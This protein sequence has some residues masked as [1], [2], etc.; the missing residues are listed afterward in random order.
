MSP[1]FKPTHKHRLARAPR[2]GPWCERV[3]LPDQREL[4][5][6]PITAA[7]AEPIQAGFALLHPDEIRKRYGYAMKEI[8]NEY[9]HRL[10]HPLPGRDFVLVATDPMP[11]GQALVGA[12]A[13][14]VMDDDGHG[15][16]FAIL[17][18]HFL[19]G[20]GLG[21]HLLCRL[22]QWGRRKRLREIHG[23]VLADNHPMLELAHALGFVRDNNH[24]PDDMVHVRLRLR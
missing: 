7:D 4:W 20:Q 13:R 9:A 21:R 6:R 14:L 16:E 3:H 2:P 24:E 19:A 8:S 18:S 10:C 12:V 23:D 11:P 15:A 17:V 5:I 1:M 22:I